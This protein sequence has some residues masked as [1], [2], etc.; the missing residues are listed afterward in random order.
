MMTT[1]SSLVSGHRTRNK[2]C[3]VFSADALAYQEFCFNFFRYNR[4]FL[5]GG[6]LLAD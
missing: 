3:H 2:A 6:L 4:Y 5:M 1:L